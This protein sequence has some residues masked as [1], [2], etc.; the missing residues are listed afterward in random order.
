MWDDDDLWV[1]GELLLP[2]GFVLM[3]NTTIFGA[4]R[5]FQGRSA[6]HRPMP[7]GVDLRSLMDVLEAIVLVEG[8]SVDNSSRDDHVVWPELHQV[9]RANGR[10]FRETDMVSGSGTLHAALLQTGAREV[11]RLLRSGQLGEH[12]GF[13]PSSDTLEVLPLHYR[14]STEFVDLTMEGVDPAHERTVARDLR[15]LV[16]LL[17]RQETATRSFALFAFRGFYYQGMAYSGGTPYMPHTWRSSLIRSRPEE[18][19][20]SFRDLVVSRATGIREGV[21]SQINNGF[22][23]AAVSADFPLIASYVVSQCATRGALLETA[24]EVRRSAKATAFRNW[25]REIDCKL[26]N[27][28]DLISVRAAQEEV[29]T[30]VH[31]LELDLGLARSEKQQVTLTLG[32]PIA[33]AETMVPL[34]R[35][36]R[37]LRR[38]LRRRPHLVFLRELARESARLTPFA[39]AFQRLGP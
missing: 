21:R 22:G 30:L 8:F 28:E 37:M 19:P 31:E 1:G 13:V 24:V 38:M 16:H 9:S 34:P 18:Q 39:L 2:H 10:F 32:L 25:I 23:G 7:S 3:D 36:P 6:Y 11:M 12:L 33:S 14:D 17:D 26:R 15:E 20:I 5:A 29:R 35:S 4:R 27:Q